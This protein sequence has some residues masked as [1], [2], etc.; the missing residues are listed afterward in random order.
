MPYWIIIAINHPDMKQSNLKIENLLQNAISN[1][2]SVARLISSCNITIRDE[3]AEYCL[4][5]HKCPNYGLAPS[6]PPHVSGPAGF[7]EFI[8]NLPQAIVV[9]FD[10]PT[11][12]LMSDERRVFY[13][14]LHEVVAGVEHDAAEMGYTESKA[15]AGGSCKTIFCY[16]HEKCNQLFGT[17]ECLHPQLARPSMSGFGVDIAALMATCG[18]SADFVTHGIG[19]NANEM[20][21]IAG[22]ILIG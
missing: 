16:E 15:F 21:W 2:A 17:G 22:L 12:V 8:K 10:V 13:R 4:E 20:S 3:L 14:R 11:K 1:G 7:R 19:E 5:P 6:C 9:K 18:W